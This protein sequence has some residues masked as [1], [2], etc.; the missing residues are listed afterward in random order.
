MD[1]F[2]HE[3]PFLA[4]RNVLLRVMGKLNQVGN[5]STWNICSQFPRVHEGLED[6]KGGKQGLSG[7]VGY[8][9][10]VVGLK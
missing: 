5:M 9:G 4:D 3:H 2:H 1:W 7:F 8:E 6:S 10:I